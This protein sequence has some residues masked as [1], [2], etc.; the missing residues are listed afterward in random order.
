[1]TKCIFCNLDRESNLNGKRIVRESPNTTTILSD[2]YL[3]KGHSLVIPKTHVEKLSELSREIRH[4]LI[5]EIT[6]V[7]ELLMKKLK[8]SGVDLRQNYRPFLP[9]SKTKVNHL[10][11]H[12]IPRWFEDILYRKSMIHEKEVFTDLT[13]ELSKELMENIK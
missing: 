11:F 4:E 1:M 10:H 9:P 13:L 3:M 6:N 2:P 5:D 8:V 7:A 12:V